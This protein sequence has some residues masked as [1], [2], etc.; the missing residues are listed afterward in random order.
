MRASEFIR[1]DK[2]R[3]GAIASIPGAHMYPD[4][5]NSNPY[6]SYR[7]GVAMAGAPDYMMDKDGPSGQ[8]MVTI[9]YS[10]ACNDITQST[11]KNLGFKRKELTTKGSNETDTVDTK[12]P[13]ANWMNPP[14]EK[15]VKKK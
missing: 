13:V 9:G 3:K 10:K 1:E 2:L 8:H 15:K 11:A 4:L 7:F 6:H 14:K 12:S 5:D